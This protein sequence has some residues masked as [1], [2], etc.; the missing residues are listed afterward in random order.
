M[1]KKNYLTAHFMNVALFLFG[2][3]ITFYNETA[4]IPAFARK[5]RTSC[6]TCHIV[7]TKRNAFGEAFRRNGYVMPKNNARLTKE[8]P[9]SLGA[10]AW[11][12]VWPDAIW[13]GDIPGTFP[14]AAYTHMRFVYDVP[15]SKK[16]NQAEFD[17]PHEFE[18]LIGGAFGEDIGFFGEWVA[19]EKGVNAPGLKRFFFQFNDIIG[20]KDALNVRVGRFEPGITDGYT[21]TQ[22]LT[23]EHPITLDY[24][25]SG[26]WRP[27]DPQAGIELNGV[28]QHRTYYA[29][30]VVNGEGK[31]VSDP[32]D[33]KDVYARV[34]HTFGG[35]GF[36]GNGL[37]S[38]AAQTDNS[39]DNAFTLGVYSYFGNTQ[40]TASGV[41]YNNDFTRF[42]LDARAQFG[43]L[44]LLGG[45]IIGKDQ[46]P[47]GDNKELNNVAYFIEGNYIFYPWLLGVLRVERA[48]STKD[49]D[50]VDKYT[51][52]N[53]N[54]TILFRANVRF[55]VEGLIN[56]QN[57]RRVGGQVV[58]V[59]NNEPLKWIKLNAMFAF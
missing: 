14:L 5:Y 45:V 38:V 54:I 39:F 13:P 42:G 53:L 32:D 24:K 12:E 3:V 30:G 48:G 20:I 21:D 49:N 11:K 58:T 25:A 27:R 19:F 50:D 34:A 29:L 31:T 8:Q 9:V 15:T 57:N 59:S 33:R 26:D 17:M 47:G 40:K 35:I 28:L 6:T 36:D 1:K 37:D 22:R 55:S 46:N 23:M 16:G 4:A 52:I 18:L 44:D 43:K 10:E 51:N 2:F 56:I 41:T 7:I